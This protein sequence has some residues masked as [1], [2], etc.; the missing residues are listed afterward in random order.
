MV[1]NPTMPLKDLS[2]EMHTDY[3]LNLLRET[4]RRKLCD[5]AKIRIGV[6][7]AKQD[8]TSDQIDHGMPRRGTDHSSTNLKAWILRPSSVTPQG[9]IDWSRTERFFPA[10][11]ATL[12]QQQLHGDS[13][14]LCLRGAFRAAWIRPEALKMTEDHV[15]NPVPV[16]AS[17][18]WA[19]IQPDSRDLT[20]AFLEWHLQ[21]NRTVAALQSRRIGTNVSYLTV[22]EVQQF[23]M[24][25]PTLRAQQTLTQLAHLISQVENLETERNA[26]LRKYLAATISLSTPAQ[27]NRQSQS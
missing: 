10:S 20:C 25:I 6:L 19:V 9:R 13:V 16:V 26:L 14:L 22:A 21:Q 27:S 12:E 4:R 18:E 5:V 15:Q 3:F 1:L 17:S 24:P 8:H 11:Q 7:P 23:E 2:P